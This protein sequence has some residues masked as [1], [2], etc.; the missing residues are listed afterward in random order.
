MAETDVERARNAS[1]ADRDVDDDGPRQTVRRMPGELAGEDVEVG[2]FFPSGMSAP[3]AAL[4]GATA[5]L[6]EDELATVKG[7]NVGKNVQQGRGAA[8]DE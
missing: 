5:D 3:E 2:P 6:N 8:S 4:S 7:E 1:R